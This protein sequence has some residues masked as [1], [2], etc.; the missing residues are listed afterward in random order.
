[1]KK[2]DV[3]ISSIAITNEA[4]QFKKRE[5]KSKYDQVFESLEPNKRLKMPSSEVSTVSKA[6]RAWL[7]RR[8]L[9]DNVKIV[10]KCEDGMGGVWWFNEPKQKAAA[11][12][13][14]PKTA[15]VGLIKKAA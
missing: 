10:A 6:L 5:I 9:P 14:A 7:K 15:W 2:N 3:D 12:Q 4:Y 8:G 1:M 13:S 11:K